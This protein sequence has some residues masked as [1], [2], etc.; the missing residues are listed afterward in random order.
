MS[1]SIDIA[2]TKALIRCAVTVH[3][4]KG[5]ISPDYLLDNHLIQIVKYQG[6]LSRLSLLFVDT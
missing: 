4:K 5:R 6:A 3:A 2:K 1:R